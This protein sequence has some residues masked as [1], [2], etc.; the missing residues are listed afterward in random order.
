MNSDWKAFLERHGGEPTGETREAQDCLLFDLSHLGLI[1]VSGEDARNFLQGQFTNDIR[2]V[3]SDHYQFSAYCTPKGRMLATLLVF[4]HDGDIHLQLPMATHQAVLQRLPLFVLM[5]KVQIEDASDRLVRIGLAGPCAETLLQ[6]AFPGLSL[7]GAPG[8]AR[9]TPG[10]TLL[11]LPGDPPRF[12]LIG[13]TEAMIPLWERFADSAA[14]GTPDRWALLDIQAG[15]PVVQEGTIEAFVPQ[16]ANLQ[17]IGGVSF[18]KG[19]YT[20]QEVV[21]RMRYL[22]KLKR[23]MY[24]AH[25]ETDQ[26]PHPGDPVFS[27]TSQ[28]GQGAGKVVDA[29][30]TPDGGYDLLVVAEIALAEADDLHLLAEDGP[31]LRLQSLPYPMEQA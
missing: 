24:L 5:A 4:E 28:S 10:I 8:E 7:P 20:G 6:D 31:I 17:L 21:A 23:R 3:G 27:R 14:T 11:R 22:G 19:C 25:V 12:E 16:M 2:D 9:Q 1:R 26:P 13:E 18:T 29:R 15:I 30:P